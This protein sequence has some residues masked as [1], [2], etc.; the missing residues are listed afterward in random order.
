[1][2]FTLFHADYVSCYRDDV[3]NPDDASSMQAYQANGRQNVLY[4]KLDTIPLSSG[5]TRTVTIPAL[6]RVEWVFIVAK[7]IGS[8]ALNTTGVD[9]D[10]ITSVTGKL[11]AYGTALFPGFL[12]L[13]TYNLDSITVTADADA[14]T[15]E[16]IACIACDDNDARLTTNA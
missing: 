2:I 8:A 9:T 15:V 11:P 14:T 1:M 3:D 13:S 5:A 12:K 4:R 6:A 7:V 16:L 10:G